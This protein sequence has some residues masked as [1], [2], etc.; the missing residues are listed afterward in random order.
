MAREALIVA[1]TQSIEDT[2]EGLHARVIYHSPVRGRSCQLAVANFTGIIFP[3]GQK[4]IKN[5][6]RVQ[7]I[8]NYSDL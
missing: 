6:L 8:E 3:L 5:A 4:P 1:A 7:I 2:L